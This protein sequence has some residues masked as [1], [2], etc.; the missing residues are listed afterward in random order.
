MSRA[1]PALVWLGALALAT[2]ALA[3]GPKA[4]RVI[5]GLKSRS[6][7]VRLK[8]A[9][10]AGQRKITRATPALRKVAD[11]QREKPAVRAAA[12]NSLGQLGDQDSRARCAY[13]AGHAQAVIANAARRALGM[14]DKALPSQPFF[15]VA[16]DPPGLPKGA[17]KRAAQQLMQAL[18]RRVRSTNGLVLGHGEQKYMSKAAFAEH[19]G[20]RDLVGLLLKP[21]LAKLTATPAD[22][23]TTVVALV[24]L[25]QIRLPGREREFTAEGGADAWIESERLTKR[26]RQELEDEVI[27]GAADAA[28]MQLLQDLQE[29]AE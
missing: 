7:K 10:V 24:R 14:L 15:L 4:G 5:K 29:R 19:L 25:I 8:A 6:L 12:L 11:N 13:L 3:G 2:P 9:T 17:S 28:L 20:Q 26:E 21:Q 22:G 27:E 1:V 16:I 23:R 18:Q